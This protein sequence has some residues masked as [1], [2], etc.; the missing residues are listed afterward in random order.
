TSFT[1]LEQRSYRLVTVPPVGT[2]RVAALTLFDNPRTENCPPRPGVIYISCPSVIDAARIAAD[3]HRFRR[4][5][6]K[7]ARAFEDA[8]FAA[9]FSDLAA[10]PGAPCPEGEGWVL[11]AAVGDRYRAV[12]GSSCDPRGLQSVL[13]AIRHL[14]GEDRRRTN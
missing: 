10:G 6:L 11:E 8:L 12:T 5:S 4:A 14:A 1:Q 9:G 7:R 13:D 2:P 3:G